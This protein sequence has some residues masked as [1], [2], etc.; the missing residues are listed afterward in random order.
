M[1]NFNNFS[2]VNNFHFALFPLEVKFVLLYEP[3]G[4]QLNN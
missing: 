2:I 1:L 3:H 4:K